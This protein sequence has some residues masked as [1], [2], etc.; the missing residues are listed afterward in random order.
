MQKSR[1]LA[2]NKDF[3]FPN[4]RLTP[5]GKCIKINLI[6]QIH[7]KKKLPVTLHLHSTPTRPLPATPMLHPAMVPARQL[8]D[9]PDELLIQIFSLLPSQHD[10]FTTCLVSRRLNSL[11]DPVL[12]KSI[13]FDQPKHH[14]TFS[15]SLITRPRRGS[16]IQ[17]VR[18]EYPSSELSEFMSLKDGEEERVRGMGVGRVDRFSHT[19]ST[20]SN[21]ENLVISVPESLCRGIGNLFNGPFD[22]ACLKSCESPPSLFTSPNYQ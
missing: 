21:L 4:Q 20:M 3:T 18:I 9:L 14:F 6:S 17:H 22:L 10:L 8:L 16:L 15:E 19:L 1:V 2:R 7:R 11:A 5:R 12:H 13:L